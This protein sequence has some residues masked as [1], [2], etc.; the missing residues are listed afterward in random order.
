MDP[1]TLVAGAQL[2]NLAIT[3][4]EQ[5]ANG[6][7]TQQQAHDQ[8]VSAAASV[9]TAISNFNAAAKAKGVAVSG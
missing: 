3:T 9:L 2:A 1:A 6:T 5:Y 8:L 7:I 4:I